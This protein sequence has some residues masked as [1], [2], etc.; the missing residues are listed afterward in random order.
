M[1]ARGKRPSLRPAR[2]GRMTTPRHCRCP[3]GRSWHPFNEN[4]PSQKLS[5]ITFA[6]RAG[7][8]TVTVR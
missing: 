3:V 6:E 5:T 1:I 8:T 2:T 7:K 4:R